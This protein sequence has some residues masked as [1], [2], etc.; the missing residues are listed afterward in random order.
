MSLSKDFDLH[1]TM[2]LQSLNR[3]RNGVPSGMPEQLGEVSAILTTYDTAQAKI[4]ADANLTP[5]GKAS[6]IKDARDAALA[7]VQQWKASRTNGIDAQTIVTRAALHKQADKALP[8]PTAMAVENMVT[9]LS[10]F[11][12]LEVEL[13]YADATDAERRVIE[14]AA[15]AIGRAPKRVS[16]PGGEQQVVWAH[17]LAPERVAAVREAR[18]EQ[19]NPD[20]AAALRNLEIIRGTYDALGSAA[21]GLLRGA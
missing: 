19:V 14:T 18:L 15:E 1:Q 8:A 4:A 3:L 6:Q 13:L 17:L 12:S 2:H 10:A 5:A 20:G 11:N 9:R 16:L 21:A 7:A